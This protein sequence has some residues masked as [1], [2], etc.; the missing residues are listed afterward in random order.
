[1]ATTDGT[2]PPQGTEP[3]PAEDHP[4]GHRLSGPAAALMNAAGFGA[5]YLWAGLGAFAF[6]SWC[7]TVPLVLVANAVNASDTPAFW[8][9]VYAL[10]LGLMA[11]GGWKWT[12][13]RRVP[14]PA[15]VAAPRRPWVPV[16]AGAAL[17][18]VVATGLVLFRAAPGSAFAEGQEAHAAGDCEAALPHYDR[19]TRVRYEF[20]L[21]GAI[22]D[23]RAERAHCEALLTAAEREA[24]DGA[25]EAIDAYQAYLDGYPGSPTWRDA[26]AHVAGLRLAH[27]DA[28]A[29][30]ARHLQAVEA[31]G[32]L[33]AHQ[34]DTDEAALVPG[35]LDR[36]FAEGTPALAAGDLCA[37]VD[38]LAPFAALGEDSQLPEAAYLAD[39]AGEELPS[40]R[41]GC[42]ERQRDD[43]DHCAAMDTFAGIGGTR[44]EE[45]ANRARFD[46]AA[47]RADDGEHCAALDTYADVAGE[48]ADRAASRARD[49]RYD[50]AEEAYGAEDLDRAEELARQVADD[51]GAQAED[52]ADLLIAIEISRIARDGA[53]GE[54]PPPSASG[55]APGGTSEVTIWNASGEDLSIL[56][57]GPETGSI[58]LPAGSDDTSACYSDALPSTTLSLPPGDYTVV[59]RTPS[60]PSINPFAGDWPMTSGTGYQNCFYISF[61]G[62]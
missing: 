14:K 53:T 33:T 50:C 32:A 59:A 22:G 18:A 7:V 39:R 19:A 12:R 10:W 51:D 35:R 15:R 57:T 20:T 44:A 46:C 54:L 62:F 58:D 49:A 52:A 28:L 11:R 37:A 3:R 9:P 45:A 23:A 31:Y 1:M 27:A 47:A 29:A 21:A 61:F 43:G 8:V 41:Y 4:P 24:T 56:W 25:T 42:G 60:D 30:D 2:R 38:E 26:P 6:L 5:G 17:L 40:A 34:P 48:L 13:D 55:G 36:L 16:A